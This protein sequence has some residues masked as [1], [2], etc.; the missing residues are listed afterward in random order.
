VLLKDRRAREPLLRP[1]AR[2]V[3]DEPQEVARD[4]RKYEA[5]LRLRA[6]AKW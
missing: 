4:E 5:A 6:A 3:V 1:W 2:L